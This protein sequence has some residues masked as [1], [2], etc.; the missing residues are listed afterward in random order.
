MRV[1]IGLVM[2]LALLRASPC[3][4][5]AARYVLEYAA[6]A[7]C[8]AQ[9]RFERLVDYYLEGEA[10]AA[11]AHVQVSLRVVDAQ[12]EGT[13]ALQRADGSVY[14]RDLTAA[15][16][17]DVAPALAFVLAYALS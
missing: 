15:T 2:V 13:F 5:Q 12:A 14:T 6:D 3:R 8:P 9:P 17:E 16:C 4:A 7:T 1:S 10:P 11:G